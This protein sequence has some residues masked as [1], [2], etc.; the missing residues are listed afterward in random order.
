MIM[1]KKEDPAVDF[2]RAML[3]EKYMKYYRKDD[4][5]LIYPYTCRRVSDLL[6]IGVLKPEFILENAD[7]VF[8]PCINDANS[9]TNAIRK[10]EHS[11]YYLSKEECELKSLDDVVKVWKDLCK[12]FFD[13]RLLELTY[14]DIGAKNGEYSGNI[15][16]YVRTLTK[17]SKTSVSLAIQTAVPFFDK[18]AGTKCINGFMSTVIDSF[19]RC[20][21]NYSGLKTAE[22]KKQPLSDEVNV[23]FMTFEAIYSE[24]I[25]ELSDD[26]YHITSCD[27]LKSIKANGLVPKSCKS[28]NFQHPSRV[29]LFSNALVNNM[30]DFMS[31]RFGIEE[32]PCMLKINKQALVSSDSFK[33]G[34]MKF[35]VDPMFTQKYGTIALFT[36]IV[37]P[38]K[39]L[40]DEVVCFKFDAYKNVL[41]DKT[42]KLRDL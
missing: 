23:L 31:E 15:V 5:P 35:Y 19:N 14:D 38:A 18:D 25:D 36:D 29:Y 21:Y 20:G 13:K 10:L 26:I 9:L 17:N 11:E 4:V 39:L 27:A 30:L 3:N 32:H 22:T 16:D 41:K 12:R 24:V 1:T 34:K 33:S 2:K 42:I 8:Y 7:D 37:I 40:D 28:G 6:N